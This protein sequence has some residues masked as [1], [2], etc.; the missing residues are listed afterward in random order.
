[1]IRFAISALVIAAVLA[2]L[3][4]WQRR[5][6]AAIA[7]ALWLLYAIYE[8]LMYARVL[9]SGECDIRVDLLLIG[10]VLLVLANNAVINTGMHWY[11][12]RR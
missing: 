4:S 1:M 2:A 8:G 6:S 12:N 3:W 10:P 7:A 9:C 11:R 5:R